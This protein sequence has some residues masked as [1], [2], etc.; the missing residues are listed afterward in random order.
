MRTVRLF[1]TIVIVLSLIVVTV[2]PAS[3]GK[4]KPTKEKP[5]KV[6]HKEP[7]GQGKKETPQAT[8]TPRPDDDPDARVVICHK[9]GTP[10]EKT[11]TVPQSAVPGHLGHGDTLGPCPEAT[12]TPTATATVPITPTAIPSDTMTICHKPGTPATGGHPPVVVDGLSSVQAQFHVPAGR[13]QP[14]P[15]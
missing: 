3:A 14:I 10:A 5:T 9:P 2:A 13:D 11:L 7:P 6:V 1:V 8:H 4:D 12:P 15:D